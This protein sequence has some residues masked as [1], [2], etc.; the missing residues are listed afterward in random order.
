M[1][2]LYCYV[3]ESGQDPKSEFFVVVAVTTEK[4]LD[5]IREQ[6]IDIEQQAGTNRKKW[7]KVRHYNRI[8]YLS[9]VV[10]RKIAAGEVY[11]S[12][13][14]KPIPYFFPMLS[15]LQKAIKEVAQDSYRANVYV[16]GIDR[17]KAKE[18]TNAL[19]ASGISLR[20]VK[21]TR[22]ESE[23][24][25][26]LADM[27]AGCARSALLRRKDAQDIVKRAKKEGYLRELQS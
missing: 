12:H 15:I 21:S 2:K 4:H 8:R 13:H 19:R 25:I 27:W 9:L 26:R 1:Q 6:L 24:L 10:E 14:K 11:V 17:Q 20:M 16:D 5:Y 23:P 18:L 3:D 22:D 7:H